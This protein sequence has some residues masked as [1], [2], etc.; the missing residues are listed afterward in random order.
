MTIHLCVDGADVAVERGDVSLL[1][2]LRDE[3]HIRGPKDGCSPQGQCGCCTVLVDGVARVAC[4]TPVRRVAG[5]SV[6]T[7]DGLDPAIALP[8]AEALA[9]AGASQCGFCTPGIMCRLSTLGPAPTPE[10]V[11][12]ALLAHLCRCT[13]WRSIVEAV[14]AET[15]LST[16]PGRPTEPGPDDAGAGAGGTEAGG[17]GA[18]RDQAAAA[19]RATIEGG[20]GQTVGTEVTFGRGGFADDTA[21]PDALVAVPAGPE[22]WAVGESV[23]EARAA[24]G[25]IQGRRSGAALVWPVAVPPGDWDLTLQTTWVEPGYLEPDASWCRPGGVAASPLANGGAFGG[26]VASPVAAAARMLA[27]RHGR[28]V[29]VLYTREDVV[30]LG[31][32]RPPVGAGIRADGTGVVRVAATAGIA[33]AIRTAAPGLVVEEVEV[34]GPP[35]SVAL[36]AAGW[37]EASILLAAVEALRAGRVPVP[38]VARSGPATVT[39]SARTGTATVAGPAGATAQAGVELDATGRPAGVT[40]EVDCGT[41]LDAAVVRS[42][43]TGAAHMALGWVLAEAVAVDSDGVPEDLTV[44]SWGILRARDTPPIAIT[45]APSDGPPVPG[46]DAVFAA[47]AAAT[48]IAL[49]L[50]SRWPATR[51]A[52]R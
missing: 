30:R 50:P 47:V 20:V 29:R 33:A 31:P 38:P 6:T 11:E 39:G 37:A 48:W 22:R 14:S 3:L 2:A 28:P 15:V 40:V 21:P 9:A 34:T 42:Y 45:V 16:D 12:T 32:K 41:P 24:A 4:V 25:K 27:D 43:A 18:G 46:A 52:G 44:R 36:R 35:T 51:S 8:L 10:R 23:E 1:A 13:G 49:G 19:R 26:K 7:V 17:T 5:R